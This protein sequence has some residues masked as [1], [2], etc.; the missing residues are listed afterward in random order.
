MVVTPSKDEYRYNET[1]SLEC[2]E[3]YT[4]QGPS[5]ATCQQEFN[6]LSPPSCI[7][8]DW[9]I[10]YIVFYAVSAIF[11]PYNGGCIGKVSLI[12]CLFWGHFVQLCNIEGFCL[13][14]VWWFYEMNL[15]VFFSGSSRYDDWKSHMIYDGLRLMFLMNY[16]TINLLL[17]EIFFSSER[18]NLM[19]T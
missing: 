17:T 13:I 7:G 6:I 10:D 4:L 11:R 14:L 3:G 5:T 8:K 15:N 1:V 2:E 9:L 19:S 18:L 12:N 16:I